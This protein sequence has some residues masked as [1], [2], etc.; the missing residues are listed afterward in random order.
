[1]PSGAFAVT[2]LVQGLLL[3]STD[4]LFFYNTK[5]G[6]NNIVYTYVLDEIQVQN[7]EI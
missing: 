6:S 3:H 5:P 2:R 4:I 7:D 1:M